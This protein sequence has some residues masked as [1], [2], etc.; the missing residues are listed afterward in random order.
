MYSIYIFV[1][2]CVYVCIWIRIC[3]YTESELDLLECLIVYSSVSSIR[4]VLSKK[5]QESTICLGWMSQMVFRMCWNQ[6][7]NK[8]SHS[9]DHL[10]ISGFSKQRNEHTKNPH[11]KSKPNKQTSKQ[12]KSRKDKRRIYLRV[13]FLMPAL[14]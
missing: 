10:V 2:V 4:A 5:S 12:T 9:I 11:T 1:Y 6:V 8:T 13:H 14:T 3:I 7:D